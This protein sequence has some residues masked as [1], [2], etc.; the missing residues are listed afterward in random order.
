MPDRHHFIAILSHALL[1]L[2]LTGCA[3][4]KLVGSVWIPTDMYS[5]LPLPD[6]ELAGIYTAVHT[7][8]GQRADPGMS[9]TYQGKLWIVGLVG[10]DGKSC[11]PGLLNYGRPTDKYEKHC[12]K[13]T[14]IT[15]GAHQLTVIMQTPFVITTGF[16]ELEWYQTR[17][18]E[19]FTPTPLKKGTMY[20]LVP[21][22][23]GAP[24][25]PTAILVEACSVIDYIESA[26]RLYKTGGC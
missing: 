8:A 15:P 13:T 5:G 7:S 25:S 16:T 3:N 4:G 6:S 1:A 22:F 12:S 9:V 11:A 20:K 23:S 17:S 21:D 26:K 19:V 2:L 10:V 24:G 14:R 18:I